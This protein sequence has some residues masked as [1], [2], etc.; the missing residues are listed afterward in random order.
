MSL[1]QYILFTVIQT[2]SRSMQSTDNVTFCR[3]V[4][5]RDVSSKGF[6]TRADS[7]L[8]ARVSSQLELDTSYTNNCHYFPIIYIY[9]LFPLLR[10]LY[11]VEKMK[12]QDLSLSWLQN[13]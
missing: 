4:C 7:T 9:K 13:I 10:L 2:L 8:V 1:F 11:S 12:C 3:E 6:S 5:T